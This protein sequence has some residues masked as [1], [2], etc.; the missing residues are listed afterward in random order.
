MSI[1]TDPTT[2]GH[3]ASGDLYSNLSGRWHASAPRRVAGA[4]D[5]NNGSRGWQAWRKYLA[6]EHRARNLR[7]WLK[8]HEPTDPPTMPGV[9]I[10]TSLVRW[11]DDAHDAPTND[12][13]AAEALAWAR[14]LAALAEEISADVWWRALGRFVELSET[15]ATMP[16]TSAPVAW[17][18]AAVELPLTLAYQFPELAACRELV[19]RAIERLATTVEEFLDA[20]GLPQ[21]EYLALLRPMLAS[22]TRSRALCEKLDD[23]RWPEPLAQ[24]FDVAVLNALRLSRRDR[25]QTFDPADAARPSLEWLV[26]A[27]RLTGDRTTVRIAKNAVDAGERR[28]P[29]KKSP[30]PAV[31][32]EPA[33][34]GLLRSDWSRGSARLAIA[35]A[36]RRVLGELSIGKHL[37]IAGDCAI[38]MR[39]NGLPAV[40]ETDWEQVCWESDDRADYLEL[41]MALAGG[42]RVQ[43]QMLLARDDHFALVADAVLCPHPAD[44]GYRAA[45]PLASDMSFEPARD[46]SEGWL[47]DGR[48]RALVLPLALPEWRSQPGPGTLTNDHGKLV[49]ELRAAKARAL[50]APLF[51]DLRPKRFAKRFTWRRLTV[52]ES[53]VTQPVDVAAGYRVHIGNAQWLVY[54]S[55]SEGVSRTVLGHHLFSEYLAARFT[56]SGTV[57]PV[58]EI[59]G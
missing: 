15:S 37:L 25:S 28:L 49:Y 23:A 9:D 14:S 34:L 43:R 3:S 8:V 20:S 38:E 7:R 30:S 53:R 57:E 26:H 52:A 41:E 2:N 29:S 32:S 13:L 54:R 24:R 47:S 58:M 19:P 45:W 11:L 50:Y 51:F 16:H 27:A 44:V 39:F 4:D 46:S 22:W 48:R 17:Q 12:A 42:F 10:E 5:W 31:Q 18:L 55:L 6:H 36:Q 33:E 1:S 35:Y 59:E 56:A 21:A 40:A